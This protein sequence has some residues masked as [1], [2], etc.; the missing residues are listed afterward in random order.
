M[1]STGTRRIELGR[2]AVQLRSLMK[3]SEQ[4]RVRALVLGLIVLSGPTAARAQSDHFTLHADSAFEAV[5]SQVAEAAS[6]R[7]GRPISVG[8]SFVPGTAMSEAPSI[9]LALVEGRAQL[10]T[11]GASGSRYVTSIALGGSEA[12]TVRALALSLSALIETLDA[13]SGP[14]VEVPA[15][16]LPLLGPTDGSALRD[17]GT[18][19]QAVDYSPRPLFELRGRLG[20]G[21]QRD[22]SLAGP[23]LAAGVCLGPYCVVLDADVLTPEEDHARRSAI[24][25]YVF[26]TIGLGA[27]FLPLRAGPVRGGIGVSLLL[28]TGHLW[29]ESQGVS[30]TTFAAGAR[31]SVEGAVML[32]EPLALVAAGGV[33][34]AF[35]PTRFVRAA[36]P[37]FVED[38]IAPWVAL[39][40]R[41]CPD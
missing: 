4:S 29:I 13:D 32:A 30:E 34:V 12:A 31:F 8:D 40:L 26:A 36:E 2:C 23:G 7:L 11:R 5:A 16:E 25:S 9:G 41:I 27:R 15:S 3:R 18:P 14:A 33:D 20:L 22:V 21:P 28:R 6:R 17:L 39:G 1:H 37:V 38:V 19:F 24:V 10:S 35:N